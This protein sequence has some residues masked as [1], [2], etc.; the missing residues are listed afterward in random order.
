MKTIE[1]L[2]KLDARAKFDTPKK[3]NRSTKEIPRDIVEQLEDGKFTTEMIQDMTE[4]SILQ[5]GRNFPVYRYRTCITIHGVWP[6]VN[7]T[8]IGGYKNV[9]QNQ[10]GSVEIFYSAIDKEKID[11][12]REQLRG[13]TSPFR[14]SENSTGREFAIYRTVTKETLPQVRAELE[15]IARELSELNIYGYVNL[16]LAADM[17]RN[18][19]VLSLHPLA[20]P[21]TE[22][23]KLILKLSRLTKEE[24]EAQRDAYIKQQAQEEQ[25]R[26]ADYQA[27]KERQ[28]AAEAARAQEIVNVFKPQVAHLKEC[29]D[30]NRGILVGISASVATPQINFVF[31]RKDGNGSF[32]RIK[33]SKALSRT[34]EIDTLEWKEQKQQAAADILRSSNTYYLV[35]P[36]RKAAPAPRQT[37]ATTGKVLMTI[38]Y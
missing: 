3:L 37:A 19:L 1:T 30:L 35:E 34:L 18:Y 36:A 22:V 8:R 4:Q 17:F 15:P 28:A 31:Y 9:H 20:I 14:Y 27:L 12:I 38:N 6:E 25:Q 24:H 11:T 23:S 10:N 16:Y 5:H 33:Y 2:L 13:T 32:G 21:A 29:T 26:K 7:R